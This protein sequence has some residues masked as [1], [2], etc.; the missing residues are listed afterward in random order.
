[1]PQHILIVDDNE[2][3]RTALSI[4]L[5][6]LGY[7]VAAV[8]SGPAALTEVARQEPD[9]MLLDIVLDEDNP[10][11]MSGL[12]V[13]QQVRQRSRFIPIIM[14]TSHPQW[15]VESLGQGA[16]A[17]IEKP[18]DNTA[19]VT[20]IRTTLGAVQ[21]IRSEAQADDQRDTLTVGSQIVIDLHYFRVSQAGTEIDLTPMEF[22]LLAFLARHPN[23]VWTRD[24]LLD[25][26]WNDSWAGYPRTVDR[27]IAALRK[28]LKLQRDELIR[29]VHGIG[30][31]LGVE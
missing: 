29:T 23:R 16:I 15:E 21:H 26:V 3:I 12:E 24:E 10:S 11:A 14:L 22:A 9:L 17:F 4:F 7:S 2:A 5:Q 31:T 8:S 1:M 30:Y 28:K 6:R 20:Q 19:L 13:C 25:H 18:W 27:H